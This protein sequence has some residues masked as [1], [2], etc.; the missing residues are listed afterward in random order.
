[1]LNVFGGGTAFLIFGF[2]CVIYLVF[3]FMKIPETKGKSLEELE[4]VFIKNY[5]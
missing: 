5:K 4:K 2:M 3:L 1:L